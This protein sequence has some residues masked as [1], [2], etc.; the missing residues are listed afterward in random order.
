M[1]AAPG[2][3]QIQALLCSKP[4]RIF[5]CNASGVLL[6]YI[7]DCSVCTGG[8][9]EWK[10]HCPKPTTHQARPAFP[11]RSPIFSSKYF[12]S[13]VS[14]SLRSDPQCQFWDLHSAQSPFGSFWSFSVVSGN[15]WYFMLITVLF[16]SFWYF[17]LFL[18]LFVHSIPWL[19]KCPIGFLEVEISSF[20]LHPTQ[21]RLK[22]V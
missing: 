21:V 16:G 12:L 11:A 5:L 10:Q 20:D 13:S 19:I 6:V 14:S 22:C 17:Y 8:Q 1:V 4:G 7:E 15:C 9:L 18:V 3:S 2:R